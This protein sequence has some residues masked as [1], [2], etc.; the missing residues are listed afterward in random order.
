MNHLRIPAMMKIL[1][2]GIINKQFAKLKD[3]FPICMSCIFG[4]S[5]RQPWQ[6]KPGTIR[7]YSETETGDCVS[8]DQLVSAQPVLIP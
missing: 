8:I 1:E 4:M 6:S 2:K 7:K 3:R 5:Q